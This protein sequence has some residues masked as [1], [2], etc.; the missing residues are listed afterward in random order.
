MTSFRYTH[1]QWAAIYSAAGDNAHKLQ[2]EEIEELATV[3]LLNDRAINDSDERNERRLAIAALKS[4]LPSDEGALSRRLWLDSRIATI[5]SAR[6]PKGSREL[7]VIDA[8]T[9]WFAIGNGIP[10][11]HRQTDGPAIRF[12]KAVFDPVFAKAPGKSGGSLL[13]TTVQATLEKMLLDRAFERIG[14]I[15]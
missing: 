2:R 7:L 12:A 13:V 1:E 5:A 10:G 8:L 15:D 6:K 9:T 14:S 4:T 3:L 11:R